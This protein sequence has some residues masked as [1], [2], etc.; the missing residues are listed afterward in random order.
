MRL[1]V[2]AKRYLCAVEEAYFDCLSQA[3]VHSLEK[4][5]GPMSDE[6]VA[7]FR[8][9]PGWEDA[10]ALRRWDDLGKVV[11]REVPD[12]AAYRHLL[13]DLVAA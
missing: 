11:G 10:V 2:D 3:S 9:L 8:E 13:S 7:A 6:E 1:H 12:F 4:Q 5:G